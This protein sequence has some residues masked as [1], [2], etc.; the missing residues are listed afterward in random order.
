MH[1]I[2][3]I[4]LPHRLLQLMSS[5][6]W[7]YS[8]KRGGR[9][10]THPKRINLFRHSHQSLGLWPN[11]AVILWHHD[12]P[13]ISLIDTNYL[14]PYGITNIFLSLSLDQGLF[15]TKHHSLRCSLCQ[16]GVSVFLYILYWSRPVLNKSNHKKS[17]HLAP[18]LSA[19]ES[20]CSP[21]WS[22]E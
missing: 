16:K 4:W 13:I 15:S 3:I 5:I 10:S 19:M 17:N 1:G 11:T 8:D 2:S 21:I 9:T 12:A 20:S 14:R 7:C 6:G 18:D 22:V